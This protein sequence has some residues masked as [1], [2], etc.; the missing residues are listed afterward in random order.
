MLDESNQI[1]NDTPE[2]AILEFN[3]AAG[4]NDIKKE[5]K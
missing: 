5:I 4:G 3:T 2:K 1:A